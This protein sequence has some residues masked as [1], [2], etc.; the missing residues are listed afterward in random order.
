MLQLKRKIE[1]QQRREICV[2]RKKF[3]LY[4]ILLTF[5]ACLFAHWALSQ[6]NQS[7]FD[8]QA[9]SQDILAHLNAVIQFYRA[10]TQPIQKAGEPN[11]VVYRDQAVALSSQIAGF[12]F[13]SAKAEAALINSGQT[14]QTT[15][16]S[17]DTDRQQRTQAFKANL[18]KQINDL[19]TREAALD[20]QIA[21]AK[22]RDVAALKAQKKQLY[23]ALDL[24][25][26]M[27]DA[28]QK[29]IGMSDT[30]GHTGLA[31]DID[32]LQDSIPEL[33]SNNK[34]ASPQ[35]TALDSA[36]S[37]GVTSQGGVLFELLGTRHTLHTLQGYNDNLREQALALRTPLSSMLRNLIQRGQQLS[38]EAVNSVPSS[39]ALK[40]AARS[41]ANPPAAVETDGSAQPDSDQA[42]IDTIT[43]RFKALSAATVPL[44]QEIIL[45]DESRANLAAWQTSVDREYKSILYSILLRVL[46]ILIALGI[47]VA[48]GRI[49]TRATNR[50]I[51]DIR[52]R[53]QLL[54]VR[55]IVVG[56]LSAIVILFGFVTQFNS[57]ATF[58][59]FLT[60]G[61]A[62]GLQT[63]LLS[64]AAYFFIIGRY[65]VKVGDRITVASVTGDVIDVGLFRFYMME[66][67]G[68]GIEL[69]PTGRIAVF[70]NAVLFQTGTPLYKQMPGTEF[71]WHELTIKLTDT[72]NYKTVCD[73][74]LKETHAVYDEYRD[75]IEQQHRNIQ[76]W[77]QASIEAPA[78]QSRLQFNAGGFQLWVRFPVEIR[79]A[80]Q[81][82]EKLTQALFD[83]MARNPE[84]KSAV[85]AMPVIQASVRG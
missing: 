50:Y 79:H 74:I 26:A 23:G 38:Q 36:R 17:T 39:P 73:A 4:T 77:M 6:Q 54:I 47:I 16:S 27:K 68:S 61:I 14:S 34:T 60:A 21:A 84:V 3:G 10:V 83:L 18:E 41:S 66:L 9:R 1:N 64:V 69:N 75:R 51:R 28:M 22:P 62:V 40:H 45:L 53:R 29:I 70:S 42:D 63:I 57:I 32:R 37:S 76:N 82:D 35:L 78:V 12:A 80:A 7:G 58:A 85:A 72:A 15:P 30:H 19:E 25:N 55:R 71:A 81:T 65:G 44:S 20:K 11:D 33:Q 49:W 5:L 52:R 2:R 43:A 56:V 24:A 48:G 59:G 8:A 13:Q 31:A 46:V 67:A